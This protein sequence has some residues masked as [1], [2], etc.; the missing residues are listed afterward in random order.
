MKFIKN[1][2]KN[3]KEDTELIGYT[4]DNCEYTRFDND[5]DNNTDNNNNNNTNNNNDNNNNNSNHSA[6]GFL[7]E[8]TIIIIVGSARYS[9]ESGG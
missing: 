4:S 6:S 1:I 3:K 2:F 7:V 9:P 5:N 8:R